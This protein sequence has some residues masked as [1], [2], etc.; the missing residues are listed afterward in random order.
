MTL[1]K[2]LARLLPRGELAFRVARKIINQHEGDNDIEIETNGELRVMR[3]VM[4]HARVVFDVGANVGDWTALAIEIAPGVQVHCF[5]PSAPTF[6]VLSGRTFPANVRQN[7]FG[8][9]SVSEDRTL[10]VY[11][12]GSGA[13]SLHLREGTDGA[14]EKQESVTLKTLD[15]YSAAEEIVEIDFVKIDV[16]GHELSVFRGSERMLAAGRIG[17]V[18]FEYGGTYIDARTY[19]K[20]VFDFVS[21]VN[22]DYRFFKIFPEGP[23]LVPKYVQTLETFQYSNWL[24]ARTDWVPRLGAR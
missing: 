16:E 21:R 6:R 20:D 12:D 23:R 1:R 4:P 3:A 18:Q 13:N 11:A 14:Q 15:E 10:F 8:L 17:V 7:N 19:L 24:I 22:P 5:E 9:G 2:S